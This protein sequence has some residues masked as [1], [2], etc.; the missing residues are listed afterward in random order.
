M[1]NFKNFIT[2]TFPQTAMPQK[3]LKSS[4]SKDEIVSHWNSLTKSNIIPIT[5][6]PR[7][8]YGTSLDE[9]T[10][11]VTGSKEFVDSIMVRLKELLQFE[12][13]D[14]QLDLK[15]QASKY[16]H[17]GGMVPNFHFYYSVKYKDGYRKVPRG[18]T[19]RNG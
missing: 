7:D 14:T 8:H 10:I 13:Q 19:I 2:E 17:A 6:K 16:E 1:M 18:P 3:D 9:D 15:Y 5:P 12:T 11:R 4:Y